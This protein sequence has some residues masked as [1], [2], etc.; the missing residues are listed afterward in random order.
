MAIKLGCI[1]SLKAV[2]MGLV[3]IEALNFLF[4][5]LDNTAQVNNALLTA[6]DVID[7]DAPVNP[8]TQTR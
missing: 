2:T 5:F 6:L 8:E 7:Y 3:E 1:G 4:E